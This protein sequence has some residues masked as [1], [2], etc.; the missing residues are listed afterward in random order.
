MMIVQKIVLFLLLNIVT[1]YAHSYSH[2]ILDIHAKVIPKMILTDTKLSKK[3]RDEKIEI[4]IVYD[5]IDTKSVNYLQRKIESNYTHLGS[6]NY[7]I[8]LKEYK[9]ITQ[10]E[11]ASIYYLFDTN[12]NNI[13][14]VTALAQ[15]SSRL[16]F[17]YNNDYLDN[18]VCISLHVSKKVSPYISLESLKLSKI[19]LKNFIFNI[20]K[21]R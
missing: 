5:S 21:L 10:K 20:A 6:Y 18:G 13:N 15:K 14:K 1:L 11:R 17:S 16:S 2:V 9:D 12:Q 7:S 19:T 4:L 8:R 3:L